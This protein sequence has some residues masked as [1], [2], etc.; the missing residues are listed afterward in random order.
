M[1][2]TQNRL[3]AGGL[4]TNG[5][6]NDNIGQQQKK[7]GDCDGSCNHA[8][9]PWFAEMM[10]QLREPAQP[11]TPTG[12]RLPCCCS[13]LCPCLLWSQQPPSLFC[14]TNRKR[15]WA[16]EQSANTLWPR[17][18]TCHQHVCSLDLSGRRWLQCSNDFSRPQAVQ[19]GAETLTGY[20]LNSCS[21]ADRAGSHALRCC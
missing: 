11:C 1:S 17:P 6:G 9:G 12:P 19:A 10:A 15:P 8:T 5:L 14:A 3:K 21:S 18:R 20:T 7:T 2:S 13:L 4:G 16:E